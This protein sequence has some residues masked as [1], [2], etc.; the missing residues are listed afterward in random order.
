MDPTTKD[1]SYFRSRLQ[2]HLD[3]S[4]PES[5][6]DEHFINQRAKWAANAYSGASQVG[7]PAEECEHYADSILFEELHF[8]KFDTVISVIKDN[9]ESLM[10]EEEIRPFALKM[11]KICDSIFD[12][13]ELSDDFIYT[14]DYDKLQMELFGS[15]TMYINEKGLL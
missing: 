2:E 6:Y 12:N 11:L 14:Y 1:F 5:K 3:S 13:Y 8:S 4:F 15:I 10:M 7:N 9:F